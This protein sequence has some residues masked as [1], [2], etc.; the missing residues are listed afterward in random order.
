MSL[1]GALGDVLLRNHLLKP[2]ISC[3]VL[4]A[5]IHLVVL[6]SNLLQILIQMFLRQSL[7]LEPTM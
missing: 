2:T 6:E 7:P 4:M 5:P 3:M 1:K